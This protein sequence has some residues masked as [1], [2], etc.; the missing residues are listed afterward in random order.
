[1]TTPDRSVRRPPRRPPPRRR[2]PRRA[3]P[4]DRRLDLGLHGHGHAR[5]RRADRRAL[6]PVLRG[7]PL[8]TAGAITAEL[9]GEPHPV[10]RRRGAAD[11]AARA[12]PAAQRRR[13]GGLRRLPP[14]PARAAARARPR[15][16]RDRRRSGDGGGRVRRTASRAS[17]SSR[18]AASTRDAFWELLTAGRT[19]TRRI[20]FFDPS[21][22]R[23]QIAAE[24]DFDPPRPGSPRTTARAWT[25]TCSSRSRRPIEAVADSGLEL[26]ASTASASACA[27]GSAVG[28]TTRLEDDYVAVSDRGR[29]WLV[30]PAYAGRSSTR[31]WCRARSRAR[32][33]R[34]SAP[35]GPRSVISTGCTS[36]IDAVGYGHQ[37]IQDG[38]ADMVIAGASESGISPI[39]M[40]CFDPIRATSR[41]TT[42]PATPRGRSTATATG[43]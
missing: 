5:S 35:T 38:E 31:R 13:R 26:D 41:A 43:S 30:D 14:R 2:G 39:S 29:E 9:D 32:S 40:A 17:A 16:H 15:R 24:C 11:P 28:G 34:A 37:L 10:R 4:E 25:A 8:V 18:P 19:A 3:R 22:F 23:S 36:G 6:A 1:M 21:G 42:S 27:L 20:T 12:P 7:V 33:R